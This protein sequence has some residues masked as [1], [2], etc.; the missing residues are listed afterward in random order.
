MGLDLPLAGRAQHTEPHSLLQVSDL[1]ST[2]GT[3]VD[4]QELEPMK[5]V[6]WWLRWL[7]AWPKTPGGGVGGG[8]VVCV[9]VGGGDGVGGV[10]GTSR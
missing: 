7:L 1:G 4:G 6:S 8:V 5:A 3:F 9:W 10:G 2:N